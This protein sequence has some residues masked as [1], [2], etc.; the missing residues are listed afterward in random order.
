[1]FALAAL[2]L[3]ILSPFIHAFGSWPLITLGLAC[4]AADLCFGG[5]VW[6]PWRRQP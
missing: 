6:G 5:R 3:F 2:I 1:M 4:I